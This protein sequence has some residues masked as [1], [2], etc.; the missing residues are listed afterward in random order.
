N[1]GGQ[2]VWR[3]D[4]IDLLCMGPPRN[5]RARL[6]R[7]ARFRDFFEQAARQ[8]IDLEDLESP[9]E[10]AETD[11]DVEKARMSDAR[12]KMQRAV[13]SAVEDWYRDVLVCRQTTEAA[14]LH[15]PEQ[16]KVL[17]EQAKT[18]PPQS[19]HKIIENI[20]NTAHRFEGNLPV[21]VVMEQ[22]VF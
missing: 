8:Q 11:E 18:L 5:L 14:Q 13:L 2:P 21:Q 17:E 16:F 10:E 9:E 3:K 19:I 1:L 6:E 7:S 20:R 15:F 4:L 12:R 22:Y